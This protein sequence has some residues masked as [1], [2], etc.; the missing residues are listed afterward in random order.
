MVVCKRH[1]KVSEA[2]HQGPH[3]IHLSVHNFGNLIKI[4][5]LAIVG[6]FRVG[7]SFYLLPQPVLIGLF[8]GEGQTY[9]TIPVSFRNLDKLEIVIASCSFTIRQERQ[10]LQ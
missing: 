9:C 3:S 6:G 7:Y 1:T 8:D 2:V 5:V 10:Q 4:Q